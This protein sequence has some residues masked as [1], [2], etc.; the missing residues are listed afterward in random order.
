[1]LWMSLFAISDVYKIMKK[2]LSN[3]MQGTQQH[4]FEFKWYIGFRAE[5]ETL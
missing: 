5:D 2:H 1:M 3:F 4:K